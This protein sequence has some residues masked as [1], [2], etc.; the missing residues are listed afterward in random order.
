MNVIAMNAMVVR[1]AAPQTKHSGEIKLLAWALVF[2][3][4]AV[5]SFILGFGGVATAFAGVAKL[6]FLLFIILFV[7]SGLSGVI[8]N[9]P[10]ARRSD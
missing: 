1:G 7:V 2:F 6:L 3:L 8:K 10:L 9:R 4:L 5:V